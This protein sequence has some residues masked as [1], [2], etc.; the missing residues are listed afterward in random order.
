MVP[1][2]SLDALSDYLEHLRV[3]RGLAHNSLEA[4]AH[5]LHEFVRYVDGQGETVVSAR[6]ELIAGF[7]GTLGE[8]DIGRRSQARY[9][10]SIRGLYRFLRSQRHIEAD[11]TAL[12]EPPQNLAGLPDVLTRAD[13]E[14]LLGAPDLSDL[15]GLRDATMLYVM[16]ASGLRVSELVNLEL[17]QLSRAQG[18]LK[19]T[20]KGGKQRLVPIGDFACAMVERY[21]VGVRGSWARQGERA[22]FVTARGTRMTRQAFWKVVRRHA[23]EAGIIKP[24]SPHKLRHSFATHLLEGGADLR[25]VQE[26]LGHSDISTTQ[27]YTHVMTEHLKSVHERYHP[28]G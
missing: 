9:L 11:P 15:R 12:L 25:A 16:Y 19:I 22:L 24:I 13:V 10:S 21:L 27:V 7:L 17:D 4:Y 28:R 2:S 26:M 20:G 3:E 6:A 14:R 5:D 23:I 1:E 8:R 18:L